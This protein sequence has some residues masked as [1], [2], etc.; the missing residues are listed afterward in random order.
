MHTISNSAIFV[1]GF[2]SAADLNLETCSIPGMADHV[3]K[4]SLQH[5]LLYHYYGAQIWVSVS[6]RLHLGLAECCARSSTPSLV[7]CRRRHWCGPVSKIL[8]V[9]LKQARIS[10]VEFNCRPK[11]SFGVRS[12]P[13]E[14]AAKRSSAFQPD[15]GGRFLPRSLVAVRFCAQS[16]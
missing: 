2:P 6:V 7:A 14:V 13:R 1:F 5:Y 3:P 9:V 8:W 11:I 12:W 16:K 15:L 4:P 10:P